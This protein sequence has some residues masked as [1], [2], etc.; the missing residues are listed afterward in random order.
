MYFLVQTDTKKKIQ[1][2]DKS[3]YFFIV[4]AKS[5]DYAEP[6]DSI[7]IKKEIK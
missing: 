1:E 7:I 3:A 4:L 5:W 2:Y 6:Y